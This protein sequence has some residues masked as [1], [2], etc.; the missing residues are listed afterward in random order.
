MGRDKD[1]LYIVMSIL[2]PEFVLVADGKKRKLD[3]FK[4]KRCKHLLAKNIVFDGIVELLNNGKIKNSDI[5]K[6]IDSFC[7]K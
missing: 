7:S 6:A 3:N 1:R 2:S 5:V 4:L